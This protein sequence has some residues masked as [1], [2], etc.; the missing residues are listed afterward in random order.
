MST[1]ED[2]SEILEDIRNITYYFVKKE[3]KK[4]L[5]EKSIKYMTKDE[6]KNFT[7][8]LLEISRDEIEEFIYINLEKIMEDKIPERDK[9]TKL[10]NEIMDDKELITDNIITEIDIYQKNKQK[11][12]N[13]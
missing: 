8:S 7:T 12:K 13:N 5:K 9:I 3:Y 4:N 1:K 10:L 2:I 11:K 6:I